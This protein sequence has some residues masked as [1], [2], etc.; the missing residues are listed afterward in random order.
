MREVGEVIETFT[1]S[2]PSTDQDLFF[3]SQTRPKL[4]Y[5]LEAKTLDERLSI[6]VDAKNPL[7]TK[8]M[9]LLAFYMFSNKGASKDAVACKQEILDKSYKFKLRMDAAAAAAPALPPPATMDAT[10]VTAVAAAIPPP[11]SATTSSQSPQSLFFKAMSLIE[12]TAPTPRHEHTDAALRSLLKPETFNVLCLD[13]DVVKLWYFH[14]LAKSDSITASVL[15]FE[16]LVGYSE[17]TYEMSFTLNAQQFRYTVDGLLFEVD[18]YALYL[19]AHEFLQ[20]NGCKVYFDSPGDQPTT[21]PFQPMKHNTHIYCLTAVAKDGSIEC[22]EHYLGDKKTARISRRERMGTDTGSVEQEGFGSAHG[23]YLI[24][25]KYSITCDTNDVDEGFLLFALVTNSV[26][27]K[28][29]AAWKYNDKHVSVYNLVEC[30]LHRLL[31]NRKILRLD[32]QSSTFWEEVTSLDGVYSNHYYMANLTLASVP[33]KLCIANNAEIYTIKVTATV[34]GKDLK[35]EYEEAAGDG[36][37]TKVHTALQLLVFAISEHLDD[38]ENVKW[39]SVSFNKTERIFV[40][41]WMPAAAPVIAAYRRTAAK[42]T[43][44]RIRLLCVDTTNHVKLQITDHGNLKL[45]LG[46]DNIELDVKEMQLKAAGGPSSANLFFLL[47]AFGLQRKINKLFRYDGVQYTNFELTTFYRGLLR[48]RLCPP[49]P[50]ARAADVGVASTARQRPR[51]SGIAGSGSGS[52]L[53]SPPASTPSMPASV[54]PAG[55]KYADFKSLIPTPL[56]RENKPTYAIIRSKAGYSAWYGK[57]QINA[58]DERLRSL[59][60]GTKLAVENS[61]TTPDTRHQGV[62]RNRHVLNANEV[63]VYVKDGKAYVFDIDHRTEVTKKT[64]SEFRYG[65]EVFT[66][67]WEKESRVT[68]FDV[69]LNAR[70]IIGLLALVPGVSRFRVND[71]YLKFFKE[72]GILPIAGSAPSATGGLP[73]AVAYFGAHADSDTSSA[74]PS[75]SESDDDDEEAAA[76]QP[77]A[78]LHPARRTR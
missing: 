20:H 43:D 22:C 14:P 8:E 77:F 57:M 74:A 31:S 34:D 67:S 24:I 42:Q 12:A 65:S 59:M 50:A 4:E 28:I 25:T 41:P 26:L 76:A 6:D 55:V 68:R 54:L 56:L 2:G 11:S 47:L 61:R 48:A 19:M 73:R 39:S 7:P 62:G 29:P 10:A 63:G 23:K 27:L 75:E 60:L 49:A 17:M 40:R 16:S 53:T 21:I 46:A 32:V 66:S 44:V 51:A 38:F 18:R 78:R 9:L 69:H 71:D 37:Q 36:L 52:G 15:M 45:S 64:D 58:S 5:D 35:L 70:V 1:L 3:G 33:G 72:L 13:G 30:L